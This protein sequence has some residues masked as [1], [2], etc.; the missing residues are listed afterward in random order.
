MCI[1]D[2]R[3]AYQL[4]RLAHYAN[5]YQGVL[6]LFEFL[7]P[8]IDDQESIINYWILGHKAGALN[9]LG[10]NVKAAYLYSVIFQN[11]P[12]KRE[13]AYR[14]FNIKTD[15]E[16]KACLLLCENNMERA[17]LYAIRAN[18]DQSKAAE[19]MEQI[20]EL[21]PENLSLIHI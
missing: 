5:D 14:S 9:A 21:D 10:Q 2:R 3:Y 18:A 1:R 7:E 19:E 6:D 11:T 20:Y 12:S 4:I 15:E 13:T 16:W 17:T 8:K